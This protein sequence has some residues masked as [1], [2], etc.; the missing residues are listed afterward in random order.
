MTEEKKKVN[1][2]K[3][4]VKYGELTVEQAT[5]KLDKLSAKSGYKSPEIV[6]W[7]RSRK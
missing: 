3:T 1:G 5:D 6:A 4:A 7:L 2:L